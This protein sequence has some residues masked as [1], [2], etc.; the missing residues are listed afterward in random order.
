VNNYKAMDIA[1]YIISYVNKDEKSP[2]GG[3]TP[4]KLQKILYYV[5]TTYL[6][7]YG[8]LLFSESFRKWQYGPV[9]RE[10]YSEF[11]SV[12]INHISKPK[13]LIVHDAS[14]P[15]GRRRKEFDEDMFVDDPYFKE[16]ANSVID[17]LITSTAFE[18]VE[19]THQESAWSDY[20]P[21]IL[22]GE[23]DLRYS[24]EEL[25]QAKNILTL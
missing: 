21:E 13:S 4:L 19:I 20:E 24:L 25:N 14:A 10:V 15:F 18:L 5:A 11:K 17:A 2:L 22:S 23:S 7:R 1:N 16:V 3:L 12:G 8:Q 9:V 6:K